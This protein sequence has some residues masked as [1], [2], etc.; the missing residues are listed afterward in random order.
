MQESDLSS[1]NS[2]QIS[3]VTAKVLSSTPLAFTE[4]VKSLG[5]YPNQILCSKDYEY[6]FKRK[7]TG[8]VVSATKFPRN[9]F[10]QLASGPATL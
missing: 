6:K 7:A 3:V 10:A 4:F 8:Y 1:W 2:T 9:A 5:F